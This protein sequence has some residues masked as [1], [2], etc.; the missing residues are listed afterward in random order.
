M[1][2]EIET[3]AYNERRYSKPWIAKVDVSK[4]LSGEFQ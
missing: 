2:M 1:K 4:K 3:A